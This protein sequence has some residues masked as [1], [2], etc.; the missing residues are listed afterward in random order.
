MPQAPS[1]QQ[2]AFTSPQQPPQES[3]QE[4][5]QEYLQ[6]YPQQLILITAPVA[7]LITTPP[8]T[9]IT[10]PATPLSPQSSNYNQVLWSREQQP[11]QLQ[12]LHTHTPP[13][14]A[15]TNIEQRP[16]QGP[17]YSKEMARIAKMYTDS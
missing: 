1:Y 15:M 12:Q 7:T 10:A 14:L 5:L 17:R 4:S 9:P 16:R 8:A 6:Q 13:E 2:Q 3:P 11:Q